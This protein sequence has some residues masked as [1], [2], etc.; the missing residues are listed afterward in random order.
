MVGSRYMGVYVWRALGGS[1]PPTFP[2]RQKN[3]TGIYNTSY[4]TYE[5]V[6]GIIIDNSTTTMMKMM[7]TTVQ[8]LTN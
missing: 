1:A 2:S 3:S 7:V 4:C 8:V 6:I 5:S